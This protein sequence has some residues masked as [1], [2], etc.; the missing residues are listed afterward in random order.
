M[1]DGIDNII[2]QFED[3]AENADSIAS[4]ALYAA[5][6]ATA[7]EVHKAISNI[8]TSKPKHGTPEDPVTGATALE[9]KSLHDAVG[10]APFRSEGGAVDTS[11]GFDGH[12]DV[13][14]KRWPQGIPNA[15][16][17]RSIESGT[18]WRK[19]SPFMRKTKQKVQREIVKA[20]QEAA[21]EAINEI[22]K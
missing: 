12:S 1:T 16:I 22:M 11:V 6:G 19:K 20:A 2:S 15:V 5:A 8:P 7:D 10:I 17:A 18:S 9:K 4:K 14:T 21:E 13:K 3:L